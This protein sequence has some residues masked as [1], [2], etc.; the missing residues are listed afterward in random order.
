MS[1]WRGNGAGG[2]DLVSLHAIRSV[3]DP[4]VSDFDDDGWLDVLSIRFS[5]LDRSDVIFNG[6]S[7][8]GLGF[9]ADRSTMRWPGVADADTYNLYRGDMTAF[10]DVNVDGLVDGGYG[11]CLSA[12]E[13]DP[14]DTALT[15]TD[16]PA[17]G[18]DGYFYLRSAVI[19]SSESDLGSVSAGPARLPDVPCP[20]G[21]S[22]HGKVQGVTV[23]SDRSGD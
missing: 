21:L 18:G 16:V 8:G 13:P 23:P 2:F 3:H 9:D 4:V 14:T 20:S 6:A 12:L 22:R 5:F 19:D 15:D 17:G 1:Y 11:L 7:P 10:T